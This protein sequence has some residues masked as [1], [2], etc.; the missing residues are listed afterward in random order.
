MANHL[1]GQSSLYLRQHAHQPVDWHVFGPEA[2]AEARRRDVPVFL[3]IGYA[4]CHWCHVMAHES[5]DDETVAAYLNQHFVAI[6][7]DREE[8]PDV[9]AVYMTATQ[10]LTGEGGWP[11]TVFTLPDGRAFF[12]GTYF[13]PEPRGG[14]PSFPQILTAV[15]EAWRDRREQVTEQA[16]KLAAGLGDYAS[17]VR[18]TAQTFDDVGA[19]LAAALSAGVARLGELESPDGGF[20]TAPKF[21][22]SPLLP[23]LAGH[24]ASGLDG[25]ETAGDVLARTLA[26]MSRSALRDQL[27]GGYCRYSVTADWSVPH[28]E[29]MLYDNAQLLRGHARH[30]RLLRSPEGAIHRE[31]WAALYPESEAVAATEE[32]VAFLT[33]PSA[34]GGLRGVGPAAGAFLSALDA[35]STP[36]E[37]QLRRAGLESAGLHEREGAFAVWSLDEFREVLGDDVGVRLARALHVSERGTVSALGSPLHPGGPLSAED[38]AL[39]DSARLALLESRARRPLPVVDDKVVAAW[40]AMAVTGLVEAGLALDRPEW[41]SRAVAAGRYL[42]DVHWD[43]ASATLARVSHEGRPGA[44]AGLLEDY[45]HGLEA[46]LALYSATGDASWFAWARELAAAVEQGFL[47][48]GRLLNEDARQTGEALDPLRAA[49]GGSTAVEL[50]DGAT[51]APAGVLAAAWLTLSALTGETELRDRAV[52]LARTAAQAASGQPR[53]GGTANAVLLTAHLGVLEVALVGPEGTALDAL[54]GAAHASARPGV[55]IAWGRGEADASVPLLAGR[56]PAPDGSP[57]AFVCREMVCHAPVGTVE[58]LRAEL[59]GD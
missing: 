3:S 53:V 49:Y 27:D 41:V 38:R 34:D 51:P 13:A 47:D 45:A 21:P 20:G 40:N 29:K 32:L 57:R 37:E 28:F 54:R 48:D 59:T 25:A 33:T 15:V 17:P 2:F 1:A 4:A 42:R 24:A 50:Y 6:K 14:R 18:V 39:L 43:E 26:A 46:A 23:F 31:R 5:F 36:A 19:R 35:D 8:R 12:A 9:D 7:V 22:P 58:E 16:A 52:G 55:A 30:L 44:V 10:A 11:M 56:G